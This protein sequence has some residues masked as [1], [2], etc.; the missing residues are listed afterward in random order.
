MVKM[1]QF[2]RAGVAS[3]ALLGLVACG[4]DKTA[5]VAQ[6]PAADGLEC[7]TI[8]E[9]LYVFENVKFSSTVSPPQPQAPEQVTR[10]SAG[11]GGGVASEVRAAGYR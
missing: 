7:V 8:P 1:D 10:S 2:L 4:G 3:T 5:E 9:G 11:W 6:T